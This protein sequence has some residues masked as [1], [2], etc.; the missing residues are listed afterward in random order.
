MGM[1]ASE[2]RKAEMYAVIEQWKSG[3]KSQQAVSKEAG[4]SYHVFKYW[5]NK[6]RTEQ[7]AITKQ[8]KQLKLP[9]DKATFI[10]V[11]IEPASGFKELQ[12][13]YPNGV[14]INCSQAITAKQ[15]KELIKLF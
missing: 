14:A 11:T 1:K 15:I 10:P 2:K 7:A 8:E 9:E 5:L 6:Q 12:I 13:V 4:V 3:N